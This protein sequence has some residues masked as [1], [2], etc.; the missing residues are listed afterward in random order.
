M[1]EA[2]L[3]VTLIAYIESS[4]HTYTESL[5]N[6]RMLLMIVLIAYIGFSP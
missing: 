1:A 5:L 2:L 6:D 3:I 4:A